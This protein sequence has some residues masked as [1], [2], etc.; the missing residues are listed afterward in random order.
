MTENEYKRLDEAAKRIVKKIIADI[1]DRSGIGDEWDG[2]NSKLQ[3]GIADYWCEIIKEE[4][5][6]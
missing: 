6:L 1:Q 3:R 2:I 4:M 5:S